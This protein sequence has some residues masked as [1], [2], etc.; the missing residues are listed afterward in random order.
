MQSYAVF[1][2]PVSSAGRRCAFTL[3]ELLVVVAIIGMLIALLLPAV[4]AARAA[5]QRMQCGNHLKQFAL[6]GHN[7]HDVRD[8]FPAGI[9]MPGTYWDNR[10][11]PANSGYHRNASGATTNVA[12]GP[13]FSAIV[14]FFPFMEASAIYNEFAGSSRPPWDGNTFPPKSISILHCPSDSN[15]DRTGL[16]NNSMSNIALSL[17]DSIVVFGNTRGVVSWSYGNPFTQVPPGQESEYGP[18]YVLTA[19]E[20]AECKRQ[21]AAAMEDGIGMGAISDGTSNTVFCGELVVA[22]NTGYAHAKGG[23]HVLPSAGSSGGGAGLDTY[24]IDTNDCINNGFS[25]DRKSVRNAFT[26]TGGR[27]RR[28]LDIFGQYGWVVN[29]LLPPNAPVCVREN[30]EQTNSGAFTM[31]S[32]HSGGVNVG[33][34]DGS[35]RFVSD[36]VDTNNVGGGTAGPRNNTA[37]RSGH[38]LW[39]GASS[40]GVW[41]AMGSIA[42]GES[43]SL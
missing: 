24:T 5:A 37:G 38:P 13:R 3:V 16:N 33:F 8:M 27:G 18:G 6:A 28:P 11:P 36:G 15:A 43:A 32:F 42:G 19:A 20:S 39:S 22:V 30:H 41:G 25:N 4:Q 34:A 17:G 9:Q 23:I 10:T 35:V 7:Y 40:F 1:N 31:Q 14:A 2:H 12:R 21:G 29:T 26:A